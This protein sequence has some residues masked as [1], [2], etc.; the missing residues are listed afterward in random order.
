MKKY[1]VSSTLKD[2]SWE[3]SEIIHDNAPDAVKNLKNQDGGDIL[4]AGSSQLLRTLM[5]HNL[6][7]EYRIVLYPVVLGSGKRLFS[8]DVHAGLD[9][10]SSEDFGNGV[11]LLIY[12]PDKS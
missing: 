12:R 5:E 6:V 7:D 11:V 8:G 1:V 9:L 4:V 3:N 2:P 10:T